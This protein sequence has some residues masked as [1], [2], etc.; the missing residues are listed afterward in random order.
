MQHILI[1]DADRVHKQACSTYLQNQG[2]T[3]AEAGSAQ[4]AIGACEEYK[5][6]LILVDLQLI[7]HSGVEFLHELRSYGE[8]Q[9]IPVILLSSVP[10]N[11]LLKFD[12][13]FRQ[14]GIVRYAY[15][16]ETSLSKLHGYITE[17]LS[18]KS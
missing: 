6:D 17:I 13:S 11:S 9:K 2:F 16:P 4:T 15:K 7:G 18:G 10:E 8:W 14:L 3:T 12:D 5:P 1:V